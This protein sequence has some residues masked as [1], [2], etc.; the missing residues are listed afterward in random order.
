MGSIH[1]RLD[2]HYLDGK[3]GELFW[4]VGDELLSLINPLFE[5]IHGVLCKLSLVPSENVRREKFHSLGME[6]RRMFLGR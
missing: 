5:S 3:V 4:R 1:V 2:S 6:I